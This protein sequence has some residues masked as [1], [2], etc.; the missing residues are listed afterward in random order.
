M[1]DISTLVSGIEYK[2]GKVAGRVGVLEQEIQSLKEALIE[3]SK[4][5]DKQKDEIKQLEERNRILI[6]AKTLETTEG[7]VEAKRKINELVREIDRCIG[8]LNT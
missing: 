5:I 7:N 1:K 4:I 6:L 8:L 2:I 3:K